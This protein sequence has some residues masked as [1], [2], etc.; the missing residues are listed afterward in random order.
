MQIRILYGLIWSIVIMSEI[1]IFNH[2]W[3]E[4]FLIV[5]TPLLIGFIITDLIKLRS[6][7]EKQSTKK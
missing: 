7:N 5:L 1:Y 3:G 2:G 4:H 6:N